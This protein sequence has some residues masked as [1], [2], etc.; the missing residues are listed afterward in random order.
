MSKRKRSRNRATEAARRPSAAPAVV[1]PTSGAGIAPTR[2]AEAPR[3][4]GPTQPAAAEPEARPSAAALPARTA[5]EW[6][7]PDSLI[8]AGAMLCALL[9]YVWRLDVPKQYVFDEVYHAFTAGQLA[10]GNSDAYLWDK[11]PPPGVAYEWTHP[12]LSKLLMQLGVKLFGDNA[13]GWRI[14]SAVFG[15]LGIGLVF[16]L[17]RL[18]F[19]RIVGLFAV[20][21]LAMDGMWF[22]QSRIAMNDIFLTC[23]LLVGYLGFALYLRGPAPQTRRW[24]WLAGAGL[25]LALATKWSAAYSLGLIGL[26]AGVRELRL[27]QTRQSDRPLPALLTVVGAVG[28]LPLAI[29]VGSYVQFFAMGHT[30][31]QWRELQRQMWWYHSGLKAT[32]PW[33]S[34]WWTWPLVL[35]PVWYWLEAQPQRTANIYALGNPLIWW[36]FLPAIGYAIYRWGET[37]YRSVGL[38]IVL[39]GFLGQWLPWFFSPRISFAYHMLPSVPFGC[40]AIAYALYRLRAPR[41]AVLGYLVPVFAAFVYFFPLWAA[42]PISPAYLEQHYWMSGWKPR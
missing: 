37:R 8:L 34:R 18:L 3:A 21:L 19:N 27:I 29:Y 24:L 6:S 17:G 31:D 22:V 23:F 11:T 5:I 16:V 13:I 1:T 32:H 10:Q 28:V 14:M 41:L 2:P 26:I 12:A 20:I 42:W 4:A 25:G 39:L 9:L 38:G 15:A 33:Q 7:R 40:L 36:A 30:L 35:K